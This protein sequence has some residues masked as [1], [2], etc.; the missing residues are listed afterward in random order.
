MLAIKDSVVVRGPIKKLVLNT[1]FLAYGDTLVPN[2]AVSRDTVTMTCDWPCPQTVHL[3]IAMHLDM[4]KWTFEEAWLFATRQGQPGFFRMPLGNIYTDARLCMGGRHPGPKDTPLELWQACAAH[5]N[6]SP[7]NAD[8]IPDLAR[9][10]QLFRFGINQQAL[11]L[12]EN[13][14]E[15]CIRVSNTT[16]EAL[17]CQPTSMPF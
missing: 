17:F 8:L 15:H 9:T 3:A 5:V 16:L 10:R 6:A 14:H 7:W 4:G 2:F 13:W 12:P 1:H 11:P